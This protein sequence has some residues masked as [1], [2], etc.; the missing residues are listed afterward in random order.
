MWRFKLYLG[1]FNLPSAKEHFG[2]KKEFVNK[3]LPF[4]KMLFQN[5]ISKSFLLNCKNF[6]LLTENP[7]CVIIIYIYAGDGT[8]CSPRFRNLEEISR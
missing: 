6:S 8:Y 2:A 7:L 5:L 4:Q 3:S 1:K